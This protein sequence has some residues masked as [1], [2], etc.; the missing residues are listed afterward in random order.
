MTGPR[1]R[2]SRRA[3]VGLL[4]LL[5]VA[6]PRA[7]HA[8][9]MAEASATLAVRDGGHVELRLLVPWAELL[10]ARLLPGRPTPEFLARIAQLPPREFDAAV[11]DIRLDVERGTR[12]LAASGQRIAFRTWRWPRADEVRAALRVELMARLA[13]DEASPHPSRLL[14]TADAVMGAVP[15]ARITFPSALGPVLLVVTHPAEQWVAPGRVSGPIGLAS[16]TSPRPRTP[17]PQ[18]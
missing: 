12:L 14:T 8:H 3:C 6:G 1:V 13:G 15:E 17:S 7:A 18:R 4:A 11:A 2:W 16:T 10:R 9:E 5:L